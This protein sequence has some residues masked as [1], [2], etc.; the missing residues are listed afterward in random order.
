M[1]L[2][3]SVFEYLNQKVMYIQDVNYYFGI[4]DDFDIKFGD[5]EL[6][7]EEV[8]N[9]AKE[10][11]LEEY[12]VFTNT[13]IEE[14][15][16]KINTYNIDDVK[17]QS[18]YGQFTLC[19]HPSRKCNLNCKYCFRKSEYLG[20]QQLT[21]EVA[22]DAIDFLVDK[23][24]PCASKYVV[25]LSG[26]GEPLLQIDL[27]KQIVDYCKQKR[28]E[29]CK[30]IEVMFCTNLT[31]LTPEIV[32]Y[33]DNEPAII[34]GTSIDGDQITNDNNRVYANGKGTYNDIVKGLKMFKN[35][36]LGLAVT[37][38]P[39]NQN[40]DLIYDYLYHLP[41]VDCVS[42]KFIRC[43]DGSKYDFDNFDISYLISRYDRLC[44]NVLIELEKGNFEYLK[45]LLKGGDYFGGFIY[46]NLFKGTYKIYRCDA[47]KSRITVNNAGDIFACSVM[48]GNN[49]YRIGSIYSG[50]NKESQSKFECVTIE[51]VTQ[52]KNCEIKSICGGECYVNAY[53]KNSDFYNPIDKMCKIKLELNKL[54]MSFIDKIKNKSG[55]VYSKLI[56]LAFEI[57]SYENTPTAVWA[58]MSFLNT[59]NVIVN[60]SEVTIVLRNMT[61]W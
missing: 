13:S 49:D 24:A 23:Y 48:Y 42:M 2:K 10:N 56:D 34:L 18:S 43:Y 29:I 11:D 22:K 14:R 17:E 20:E 36:K 44:C 60:Y 47:G 8:L 45:K 27:V 46:G 3:V 9:I 35:K 51:S 21:F 52:C 28:N 4:K 50:I 12:E 32:E 7:E 15:L 6:S 39:L 30:N 41:N 26:S 58:V 55:V 5:Y 25:D 61:I 53:L 57:N 33:L 54:S 40:V 16:N 31:L 19:L 1:K 37:V 59:R 38:T